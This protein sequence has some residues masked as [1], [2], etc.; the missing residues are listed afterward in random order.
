MAVGRI[1]GGTPVKIGKIR[2]KL[3]SGAEAV[4]S[5]ILL[6]VRMNSNLEVGDVVEI[7]I[8]LYGG[9]TAQIIGTI[10]GK[11]TNYYQIYVR[12]EAEDII[13]YAEQNKLPIVALAIKKIGESRK[14]KKEPEPRRYYIPATVGEE[15]QNNEGR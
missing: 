1:M 7:L 12:R 6:P 9:F 2:K 3:R 15:K 13:K 11:Y 8:Q 14:K 10:F 4:Y 5:Y